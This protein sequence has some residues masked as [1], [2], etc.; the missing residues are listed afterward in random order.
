MTISFVL[1]NSNTHGCNPNATSASRLAFPFSHVADAAQHSFAA[2]PLGRCLRRTVENAAAVTLTFFW[3]FLLAFCLAE[4]HLSSVLRRFC[5]IGKVCCALR[6]R[7]HKLLC[8][9]YEKDLSVPRFAFLDFD[10]HGS[11]PKATSASRFLFPFSHV[12]AAAL[13]SFADSSPFW[14]LLAQNCK[15]CG[16]VHAD[17][18]LEESACFLI[19]RAA[20]DS[21][22]SSIL[23]HRHGVLCSEAALIQ[24]A[25]EKTFIRLLT[26]GAGS[27]LNG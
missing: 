26:A 22:A 1:P 9:A 15:V 11:N 14:T 3:R 8:F 21:C 7:L 12:A 10:T 5:Y 17:V 23:L 6:L 25:Y 19:G 18:F 20:P 4:L 27:A 16:C 24:L 13:Q 2:R